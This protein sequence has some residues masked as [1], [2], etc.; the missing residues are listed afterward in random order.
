[1]KRPTRLIV[2]RDTTYEMRRLLYK[3]MYLV[4]NWSLLNRTLQEQNVLSRSVLFPA[5]SNNF[6]SANHAAVEDPQVAVRN[7]G[8][9]G[10]C[11][12]C[13]C[14]LAISEAIPNSRVYVC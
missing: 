6:S 4:E 12:A 10:Y 8:P 3:L 1:M 11:V 2:V 7:S 13:F 5:W 9:S 14:T